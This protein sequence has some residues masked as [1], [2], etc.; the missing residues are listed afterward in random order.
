MERIRPA[1]VLQRRQRSFYRP[2]WAVAFIRYVDGD[3]RRPWRH[4][5]AWHNEEDDIF[6]FCYEAVPGW[7]SGLEAGLDRWAVAARLAR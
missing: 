5:A 1:K 3:G 2:T 4:R 6:V 7:L